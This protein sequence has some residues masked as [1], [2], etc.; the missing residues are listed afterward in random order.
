MKV[1]YHTTEQIE[2]IKRKQNKKGEVMWILE[3][4]QQSDYPAISINWKAEGYKTPE[5]CRCSMYKS[6]RVMH[7]KIQT[8]IN[9]DNVY[10]LKGV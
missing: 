3:E 5:S 10:I 2:T 9:G 6:A 8:I 1:T 4:F 7:F